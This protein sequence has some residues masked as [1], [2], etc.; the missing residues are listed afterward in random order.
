MRIAKDTRITE[1][2][3]QFESYRTSSTTTINTHNITIQ[4]LQTRVHNL[5][6]TIISL[7][8][9]ITKK[10]DVESQLATSQRLNVE[11]TAQKT[12][13]Q[14]QLDEASEYIID[15]EEKVYRANKT[16]LELL[17]QLKDAEV[18][19]ETLK[20]Y[21]IDLKQRIA[22]YIPVKEDGIDRRLAEYINNYPERNKLKIMFMRE[23]D[24]VYQFGSRK[25]M[26][27]VE[28]DNIKIRVGGGFLSIDAFLEQYTPQE[29]EKLERKDPLKRMSE[30]V[31]IQS[32]IKNQG[33]RES[34][35]VRV[36]TA[37]PG[38]RGSPKKLRST[39]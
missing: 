34:S 10:E 14:E 37:S 17:K 20:Q 38:R 28:K 35:P 4:T 7:K 11:L 13:L 25:V 33:V 29:L 27:K 5:Q 36:S 16:S 15:L 8:E 12:Q 21:I 22:V 24:G 23:S 26:V 2:E 32:T 1:L 19:I 39:L 9:I 6:T 30:K 31:A 3:E 18:E